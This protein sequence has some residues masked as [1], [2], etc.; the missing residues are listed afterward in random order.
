MQVN[1][2]VWRG[3]FDIEKLKWDV[4]YN[5]GAGAEILAQLLARV[6]WRE[7]DAQVENA[8]R[9][10]YCAYNGGPGAFRRYR[11]PRVPRRQRAIDEMFW[12]KYRTMAAGRAGDAVLCM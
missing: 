12:E 10:T 8:A 1:R 6:G 3:F 2:R 4:V 5:A 7:A 9:A 11:S